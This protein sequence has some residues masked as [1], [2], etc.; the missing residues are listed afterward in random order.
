MPT[1]TP[2]PEHKVIIT[3]TGR[4]GTTFMVHLLSVL[5][6]DTGISGK[7]WHKKY[8][9][10]CHAGL[11]HDILDPKTPYIVKNPA[12]C[13]TLRPA[14]ATGRFI[15]D[16][17]YVPVRDLDAVAASR[18][19]VGGTD[20]SKPGGLWGTAD[21]SRQGAVMAE[22]FHNLVHTLAVNEIP[23]TFLHFPRL[24]R[25]PAYTY[26]K[27]AFLVSGVDF[28][29]FSEAFGRVADPSLVHNFSDGAPQPAPAP[30]PAARTRKLP[31]GL[32]RLFPS[33]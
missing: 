23:V 28:A 7:N 32:G 22:L 1:P 29:T 19:S 12:L 16:H 5:G 18:A 9:E 31:L 30:A 15:I 6:L 8:F 11:E 4:A 33:W 25:D 2:A 13:E 10:H 21:P 27:L 3:G 26:R 17:A 14:L 24:V 20:G